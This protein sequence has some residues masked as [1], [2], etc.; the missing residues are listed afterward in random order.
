MGR[1]FAIIG[2]IVIIAGGS[3]I[4]YAVTRKGAGGMSPAQTAAMAKAVGQLD[5]DIKAARSEIHGHA[6]TLSGF[7]ALR[8]AIATDAATV[9]NLVVSGDISIKD[10]EIVEI[11]R[12]V[13]AGNQVEVL[14]LLPAGA[15][16]KSHGGQF[17]SYAELVGDQIVITEVDEVVPTEQANRY[18]GF[19]SVTRPLALGPAIRAL[20]EAGITGKFVVGQTDLAIGRMPERAAVREQP[21]SPPG[22]AKIIAAEPPPRAVM[23]VPVL[24]GGIGAAV[25]GL[26]LLVISIM[27]K[28]DAAFSR[29]F[30]AMPTLPS[31]PPPN[32]PETGI[33]NAQ[34]Q[35]SQHSVAAAS[36][37]LP[38][39]PTSGAQIVPSNLGAGAMI[40]RRFARA[41]SAPCARK[42]G[43]TENWDGSAHVR[44]R[45]AKC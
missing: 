21:L 28:R 19:L 44:A 11:G 43:R 1:T 40:G 27:G 39:G 10:G 7:L 24:V 42:R 32:K 23:P 12:I 25:I 14:L 9:K 22:D 8:A 16:R 29:A 6:S 2:A 5:G 37:Q 36:T 18:K 17:G 45:T 13:K 33:G 38:V 35:L 26:L 15:M 31:S 20:T 3:A 41:R 4:G 34:T 30:V